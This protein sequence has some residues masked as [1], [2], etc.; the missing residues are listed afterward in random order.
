VT[1]LT[2]FLGK[3]ED[4]SDDSDSESD[5]DNTPNAQEVW[6]A[7]RVN[8]KTR[9]RKRIL[10][11]TKQV[12]KKSK[13]KE[14]ALSFNFSAIHLIHDPQSM[15]E[16]LFKSL[17]TMN[18]RFEVKLM[19]MNLISRLVGIHELI[20][21]NFYP[22]LQRFLQPHQREVTKILQYTAQAAHELVPPDVIEPLLKL[23][24]NNFVSERNSSEV[25]AVGLNSIREL[26]ARCPL[27]MNEDLLQD[28]AEYK[29]Y[30]D[31]NVSM[32]SK[33]LIQLFRVK[34]PNLLKKKDRA[35][36]TLANS[37]IKQKQYGELSSTD[38]VDG[39][40]VLND[41]VD[42]D[43]EENES[44]QN[45]SDD[46]VSEDEDSWIDVSHSEDDEK[47]NTNENENIVPEDQIKKATLISSSRILTQEEFHKVKLAQISKQIQAAKPRRFNKNSKTDE[48]ENTSLT[49][50]NK[51]IVPLNAI[52]K[53]Y[54]KSKSNKELRLESVMSGR[55]DRGKYGAKKGKQ[56]PHAS[57]NK[58]EN[59][60]NKAFM[61]IRH[62]L[63]GKKKRSFKDKQ[64]ALR[65][66]LIKKCK[67]IK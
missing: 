14:K 45:N 47:S 28:L 3:D 44:N 8:K 48:S 63:K 26:C 27:V 35:K 22:F 36:P 9:K 54:K 34:N 56:N 11:R 51:E 15:A 31:K 21:L 19:T 10:E 66:A 67:Q 20:L 24:A 43:N 16:K 33:S 5:D 42:I 61:M 59:K 50:E 49:L 60:K 7:N 38:F 23:I 18:E 58:K 6:M 37:N 12:I 2:F 65:N 52:E 30:R 41:T 39:T 40:E 25:M 46:E 57:K 64:I 62:K 1:A 53:I 32:A 29:S 55:E 4:Q 17:E 13:K